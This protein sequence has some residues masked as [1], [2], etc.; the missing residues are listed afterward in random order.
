MVRSVIQM[1][2][3][4]NMQKEAVVILDVVA[5][6]ARNTTGC[7]G[8][9]IFRGVKDRRMIVFEQCWDNEENMN[10]HLR[11]E[12][13]NRVLLVIEMALEQPEI[14]FDRIDCSSGLDAIEAARNI[15]VEKI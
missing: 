1:L 10:I 8:C 15:E 4:F 12:I 13:Y 5:E 2:I 9:S 6:K 3:P 7:L 14:R 11:S